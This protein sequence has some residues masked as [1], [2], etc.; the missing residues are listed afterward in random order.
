MAK[1]LAV[2][3]SSLQRKTANQLTS[4][5]DQDTYL[6]LAWEKVQGDW[7]KFDPGLFRDPAKQSSTTDSS[8]VAEIDGDTA[9]LE[10]VEDSTKIKY[11]LIDNIDDV[12]DKTGYYFAGYDTTNNKREVVFLKNG[13]LQGST[14]YSYYQIKRFALTT[15]TSTAEV[16]IPDEYADVIAAK[17]S[18]LWHE[19]Q[20]PPMQ[21]TS[22]RWEA[23]YNRRIADAKAWYKNPTKDVGRVPIMDPDA[24]GGFAVAHVVS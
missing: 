11:E 8:G 4:S 6:A 13:T 18:Q 23:R 3:R 9:R 24:G 7:F 2:L 21:E 17:A 20:G 5:S 15:S 22:E 16:R 19:D 14:T 1:T 12:N 10:R